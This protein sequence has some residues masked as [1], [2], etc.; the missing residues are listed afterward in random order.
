MVKN[1]LIDAL[2]NEIMIFKDGT[3][4]PKLDMLTREYEKALKEIGWDPNKKIKITKRGEYKTS[5]PIQICLK[6]RTEVLKR[7][8]AYYYHD[9][10]MTLEEC[11]LKS[12][13]RFERL[14]DGEAR[15]SESAKVYKS[16]FKRFVGNYPIAKKPI[17]QIKTS[18]IHN[19][20]E[21][22][23]I[24]QHLTS[25]GLADARLVLSKA[26]NYA[27]NND[28]VTN[29][30]MVGLTTSDIFARE[31]NNDERVYTAEERDKLLAVM[32]DSKILSSYRKN[33]LAYVSARA[34]CL[35]FCA[36]L[37]NGEIRS[38]KW[39][40]VD[41][42]EGCESIK[43]HSQIRRHTDKDGNHCYKYSGL[44]KAKKSKGNRNPALCDFATEILKAQRAD[45]SE[46]A[47]YVFESNG[48]VLTENTLNKWLRKFCNHAN[49]DYL[50]SHSI[51]FYAVTALNAQ[52]V[53]IDK[54]QHSAGHCCPSTTE[55]YIRNA[56]AT[57]LTKDEVNAV[58]NY[59]VNDTFAL[60]Y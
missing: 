44:T 15:S 40:D 51:R 32:T 20:L 10:E 60:P 3:D 43:I 35:A 55:H 1:A 45:S 36:P 30:I 47:V 49:V 5:T 56:R 22:I 25:D 53:S 21:D 8:Y 38:L 6:N 23:A 27:Y 26:F 24:E 41:F 48:H 7:A 39:S 46:N 12:M 17:K 34:L 9:S 58:Y 11:F 59:V 42:T 52:G 19:H 29:N 50:P 13:E 37:R 57:E 4:N 16:N 33:S 28:I 14:V 54:I 31:V 18:H 2:E